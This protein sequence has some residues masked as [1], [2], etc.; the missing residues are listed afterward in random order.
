MWST[1]AQFGTAYVMTAAMET[2][3]DLAPLSARNVACMPIE[4]TTVSA[5]ATETGPTMQTKPVVVTLIL[6]CAT[7]LVLDALAHTRINA[8]AVYYMLPRMEMGIVLVIRTGGT[9]TAKN[10]SVPV[11]RIVLDV[12]KLIQLPVH[13]ANSMHTGLVMPLVT[14]RAKPGGSNPIA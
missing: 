2:V 6:A 13:S 12:V 11:T 10:G 3:L 5:Y 8:L 9:L 1:T 4:T 7:T 14:A